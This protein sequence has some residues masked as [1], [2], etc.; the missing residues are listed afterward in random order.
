M[1]KQK[2]IPFFS[3]TGNAEEAMNFYADTLPGAE[4]AS[5][6]RFG[7]DEAFGDEGKILTGILTIGGQQ[8][9]FLDMQ[10]AYPAPAFS[11]AASFILRCA[12]EAEFDEVFRQLSQGGAVMMG[13]E[14]VRQFRK[15]AWVTDR[16]GI[17]WQPVWE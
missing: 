6:E 4:I 10:P 1:D 9:M 8:I 5:I 2:L 7:K 11:W 15:A 16:F 14:P 13:P 17:T 3:F 12:D